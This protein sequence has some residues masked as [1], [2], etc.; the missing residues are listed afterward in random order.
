MAAV[1][2]GLA[3]SADVLPFEAVADFFD[4]HSLFT[5]LCSSQRGLCY[6]TSEV[7]WQGW[8][9][10]WLAKQLPGHVRWRPSQDPEFRKLC[11]CP[12]WRARFS[13]FFA[14]GIRLYERRD[15]A[16]AVDAFRRVAGCL[17]QPHGQVSCRLADAVYGQAMERK[18]SAALATESAAANSL[19][20]E[21]SD[22]SSEAVAAREMASEADVLSAES[23]RLLAEASELYR[24]A[25]ADDPTNSYAVNGLSLYAAHD[26]EKRRL[27]E[28][29]VALDGENPY[30]LANLGA[31]LL[32]EDERRALGYL[33]R[34]LAVNPRLFYARL[35]KCKA[36]MQLGNLDGAL[37]AAAQQLAFHPV[38]DLAK[39]L[40]AQL[41]ARRRELHRSMMLA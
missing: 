8:R 16:G 34:A 13:H 31:D 19:A 22:T 38:D 32:M 6:A 35:F 18:K 11:L 3:P 27:L 4:I 33:D 1:S 14:Q 40:L 29:A 17:P 25:F 10:A 15:F 36:L 39:R 12:L 41:S 21:L 5:F 28:K 24:S 20:A 37:E 26:G 2:P 23:E 9:G 7:C 30:A